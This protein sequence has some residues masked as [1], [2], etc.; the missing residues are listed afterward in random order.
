MRD[1]NRNSS[2]TKETVHTGESLLNQ[3]LVFCLLLFDK[4]SSKKPLAITDHSVD[5]NWDI[6]FWMPK[7]YHNIN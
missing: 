5:E 1:S 7:T 2:D 4:L 3:Y 6:F